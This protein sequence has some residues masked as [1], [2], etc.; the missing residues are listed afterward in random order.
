VI[1]IKLQNPLH[2]LLAS[3]Q[4]DPIIGQYANRKVKPEE[5]YFDPDIDDY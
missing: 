4:R 3:F 1:P 5:H 2:D